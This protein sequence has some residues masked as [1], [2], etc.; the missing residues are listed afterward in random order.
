MADDIDY[1]E[2]ADNTISD[3][4]DEVEG[5]DIDFQKLLEAEKNNKDRKTLKEWLQSR[6]D[7]TERYEKDEVEEGYG[8]EPVAESV[9]ED[10]GSIWTRP[11]TNFILG[12]L[13]GIAAAALVLGS[14]GGGTTTGAM[15]A[16]QVS[17]QVTDLF[18]QQIPAQSNAS[19]TVSS[20]DSS[21][22]SDMYVV[23][24]SVSAQGQSQ[25]LQAYV[26]SSSGLM[27]VQPPVD[28]E[29][30]EQ[31]GSPLGMG[32]EETATAP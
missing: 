29:T 2:L 22:Y 32:G 17:Q 4:K 27:F 15:S 24:L 14:G 1:E 18:Q 25:E 23:A 28:I 16:D 31:V 26:S 10:S 13:V 20:V 8:K 12:I 7:G 19:V 3:V 30:G 21:S 6:I 11:S 9:T 5:R